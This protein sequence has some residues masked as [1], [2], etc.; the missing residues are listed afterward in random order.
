MECYEVQR[1]N[2]PGQYMDRA[3]LAE[4]LRMNRDPQCTLYEVL[5]AACVMHLERLANNGQTQPGPRGEGEIGN[6]GD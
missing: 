4:V 2:Y 5:P 6:D 3:I 1:E